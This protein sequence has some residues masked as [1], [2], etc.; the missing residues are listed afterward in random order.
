MTKALLNSYGKFP[1]PGK[2]YIDHCDQCGV[3]AEICPADAIREENGVYLIDKDPC[4]SC[5]YCVD[6]C[7]KKVMRMIDGFPHKCIDCGECADLCPRDALKF[8]SREEMQA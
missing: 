2:Y 4:F 1:A 3:C 6:G 8:S 5:G 7:P